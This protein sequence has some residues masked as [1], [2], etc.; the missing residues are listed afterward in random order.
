[1][2]LPHC[3]GPFSSESKVR[4]SRLSN[5]L[6]HHHWMTRYYSGLLAEQGARIGIDVL[7]PL[8][9]TK[10]QS[11]IWYARES[12]GGRFWRMQPCYQNSLIITPAET[13]FPIHCP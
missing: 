10:A 12:G 6:V 7:Y 11:R 4:L 8:P 2:G 9:T 13:S 1:V 5:V 3:L